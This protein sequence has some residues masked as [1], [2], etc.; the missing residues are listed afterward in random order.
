MHLPVKHI[1]SD[2]TLWLSPE[3]SIFWEEE[4]AL[5]LADLH[6][7]KTG[8]FRKAGIAV[9][10]TIFK[11]DMQRLVSLIQFFKP[12][13][14]II[15]GDMFHSE[16]NKELEL[17]SKWRNDFSALA[18]NLIK[19][20]HDVLKNQWYIDAAITLYAEELEVNNFVFRHDY[21]AHS[22]I[23]RNGDKYLFS[24]HIH[25]GIVIRGMAKQAL[26]FSCFHFAEEYCTLPAFSRFT[27]TAAIRPGRA[28]T[29][30]AI[31][32]DKVIEWVKPL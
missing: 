2:Q 19:G 14:L 17:F 22:G 10:Q 7:G 24:G 3:K 13:Q 11:E 28:D 26:R 31:V 29:V 4:K 20:N 30:F 21:D 1:I 23:K 5:I 32:N 6:L 8:H 27:G 18:F 15:V 12:E 16:S 9:P 25:P